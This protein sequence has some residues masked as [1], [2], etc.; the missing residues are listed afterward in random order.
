[1]TDRR[2]LNVLY[3]LVVLVV[4]NLGATFYFQLTK[5]QTNPGTSHNGNTDST[6]ISAKDATDFARIA[7]DL[8]NAK[9]THGLYL[10]FDELARLKITEKEF[11]DKISKVQGMMGQLQDFA[12][13]NASIAGREG[14]RTYLVLEYRTRLAGG[15]FKAGILKLTVAMKDGH[16]SLFGFYMAGQ[17]E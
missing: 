17:E 10:K 9:N 6:L 15:T 13:A 7:I 14:D 11:S 12:Y 8:Y 2:V 4:I 5:T 1:M 16:P 3:V